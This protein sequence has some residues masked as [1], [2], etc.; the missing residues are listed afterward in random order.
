MIYGGELTDQQPFGLSLYSDVVDMDDFLRS[1]IRSAAA[2]IDVK[3]HRS[4][5]A[6]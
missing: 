6:A 4:G 1:T 2:Y 3:K 5:Q